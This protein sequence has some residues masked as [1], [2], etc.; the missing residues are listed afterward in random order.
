MGESSDLVLFIGRFH[1]VFVHLPIGF[2]LLAFLFEICSRFNRF[3]NLEPAVPFTLLLGVASAFTAAGTGY[4]LSLDGGYGEDL[5]WTHKWLGISVAVLSLCALVLRQWF[6]E[7]VQLKKLY[8]FLM[9]GMVFGL[10]GAGH[11]G[12]SLTHGSDYLV[13]YMPEPLRSITGAPVVEA[14]SIKQIENLDSAKVFM[15]VIH[16]ILDTRCV[17]CHNPEKK[18][19]EL[20]LTSYDEIMQGGD[21]GP[22]LEVGSSERSEL[23]KR[24]LLPDRHDDRM[25]PSGKQQLTDDQKDLISWWVDLGAPM[26]QAISGVEVPDEIMEKLNKLTVEG[27]NFLVRTEVNPPDKSLI[28]QLNQSGGVRI[29]RISQNSNFLQVRTT[30]GAES[31]D[32]NQLSPLSSQVTWLDLSGAAVS[33][34]SLTVLSSFR[35]LTRLNLSQTGIDGSSLQHLKGLEHLE[36]LNLY[37]TKISDQGLNHLQSLPSLKSLYLWR[38]NVSL[39]AIQQLKNNLPDVD[40][41]T[42][43]NSENIT[44]NQD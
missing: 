15:D 7:N 11:Y 35:N 9:W 3:E 29:S 44:E 4:L 37:G 23:V 38:T 36:Y 18:K 14:K 24:I 2:L 10:M 16:P 42:G 17:S 39:E 27:T 28:N 12:G 8:T 20:L 22:A 21:S 5:L 6:Y 1:P 31:I 41:N 19:G 30:N 32:L 34:S 25:P 26:D 40:I 33:D 43:V 13:R